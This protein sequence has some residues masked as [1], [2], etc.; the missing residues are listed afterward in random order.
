MSFSERKRSKRLRSRR[1]RLCDPSTNMRCLL[2]CDVIAS[3]TAAGASATGS[4]FESVSAA[5]RVLLRLYSK[6]IPLGILSISRCLSSSFQVH[7]PIHGNALPCSSRQYCE[8][9][10]ARVAPTSAS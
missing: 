9:C 4:S 8:A 10:P 1:V 6:T 5:L 3:P 7:M 2:C